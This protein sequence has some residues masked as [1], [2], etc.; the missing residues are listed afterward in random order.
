MTS[1]AL[2]YSLAFASSAQAPVQLHEDRFDNEHHHHDNNQGDDPMERS[3]E[4]QAV[5]ECE[6]ERFENDELGPEQH[7]PCAEEA[8]ES[9]KT[10]WPCV[11]EGG[12]PMLHDD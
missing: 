8:Q 7:Y 10:A 4:L 6:D 12:D 9:R 1:P 2:E 3:A 11:E 5:T